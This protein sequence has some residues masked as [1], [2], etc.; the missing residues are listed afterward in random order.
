MFITVLTAPLQLTLSS[1][2]RN[3]FHISKQYLLSDP[4]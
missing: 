2:I 4:H 1:A 3:Q